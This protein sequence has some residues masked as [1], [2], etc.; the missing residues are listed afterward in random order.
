VRV[1]P[2]PSAATPVAL[3]SPAPASSP[4][5]LLGRAFDARTAQRAIRMRW[6]DG[7]TTPV[8]TGRWLAPAGPDELE[9]LAG[10]T[11]PVLDVGCGPG[12]HV[13]ALNE[14]RVAALGIDVL[15]AAVRAGRRRGAAVEQRSVFD[16]GLQRGRW[17]T[18][19]LL[20]GNV[21]IGGDP[22]AL[23]RRVGELLRPG[24]H[25]LVELEPPGVGLRT[26]VGRLET[27]AGSSAPFAW[28][29]VGADGAHE[30]A[31]AAG[32]AVDA[33]WERRGRWFARFAK[34]A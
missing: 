21:G 29:R 17:A 19:L 1:A 18:A 23:L 26:Q 25:A 7:T 33:P 8:R 10:V 24:G 31:A 11:G 30:L 4:A 27:P 28:G 6:S 32:F 3:P 34:P 15:A 5:E 14:R 2:S 9:L 16:P 20:D 13:V 22:V 12:R